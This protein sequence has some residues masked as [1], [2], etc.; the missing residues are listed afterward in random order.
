[1]EGVGSVSFDQVPPLVWEFLA[2]LYFWVHLIVCLELNMTFDK[3]M[4]FVSSFFF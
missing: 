3:A 1:M 4:I 2:F